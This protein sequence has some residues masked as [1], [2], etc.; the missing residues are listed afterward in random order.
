MNLTSAS[1]TTEFAVEAKFSLIPH[2]LSGPVISVCG[3]M[4]WPIIALSCTCF[5]QGIYHLSE[6]S[7][8]TKS[9]ESS[10]SRN[11]IRKPLMESNART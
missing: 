1:N 4:R 5:T 6:L 3:A 10:R 8:L 7:T 11:E 9:L 2:S